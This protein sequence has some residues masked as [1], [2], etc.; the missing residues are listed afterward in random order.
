LTH[1]QRVETQR[2][3]EENKEAI[4]TRGIGRIP[5][6]RELSPPLPLSVAKTGRNNLN[7][8]ITLLFHNLG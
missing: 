8:E 4:I 7:E 3:R 1:T 2:E 5:M 6:H